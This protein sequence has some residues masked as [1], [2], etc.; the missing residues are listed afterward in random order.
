M[1][2]NISSIK[3]ISSILLF[4]LLFATTQA[5]TRLCRDTAIATYELLSIRAM[6][7]NYPYLRFDV[8]YSS[9]MYTPGFVTEQ[10]QV[11]VHNGQFL[12]K[13]NNGRLRCQNYGFN[14]SVD[15]AQK[16]LSINK[17]AEIFQVIMNFD[18]LNKTDQKY[19]LSRSYIVD[20]A[21]WRKLVIEFTPDAPWGYYSVVFDPS[22]FLPLKIRYTMKHLNS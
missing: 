19:F 9:K 13:N 2:M 7:N 21:S 4:T 22:N 16:I 20:T 18:L 15:S 14:F 3:N 1:T 6:I 17:R 5:N 11:W 8:D 10:R 12:M